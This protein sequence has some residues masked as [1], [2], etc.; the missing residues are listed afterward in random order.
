[1]SRAKKREKDRNSE[2]KQARQRR[3]CNKKG[4]S[5]CKCRHVIRISDQ[6]VIFHKA[7]YLRLIAVLEI[8]EE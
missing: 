8:C 6:Q 4:Q 2:G 1:M 3:H 5:C 7:E